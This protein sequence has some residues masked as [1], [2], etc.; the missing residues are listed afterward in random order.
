MAISKRIVAAT[1]TTVVI[2]G[3][4]IS[5][6]SLPAP[7]Q[8]AG[9][10]AREHRAHFRGKDRAGR[11]GSARAEMMRTVF[12]QADSDGDGALTQAEIDTFRSAQVDRADVSGDGALS[13][14]EFETLYREFTRNRMVNAFQRL[15]ADG[16]GQISAAE[17]DDRF[18]DVVA[19]MDRNDDG[20][21]TLQDGRRR[22]DD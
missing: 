20:V 7:A 6:H 14:D 4:I 11:H 17:M 5:A 19:R 21:L 15:D 1:L 22:H 2:A 18:G 12:R 8:E 3:G 13:L 9:I 16:D 10:D